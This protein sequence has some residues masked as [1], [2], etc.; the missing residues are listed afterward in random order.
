M[1]LTL[2]L[3]LLAQNVT[4]AATFQG[5]WDFLFELHERING[6]SHREFKFAAIPVV[7]ETDY[8]G[9]SW[10]L[11]FSDEVIA[12]SGGPDKPFETTVEI[13]GTIGTNE[14]LPLSFPDTRGTAVAGHGKIT[15]TGLTYSVTHRI[16]S[17]TQTRESN[18][19][20]ITDEHSIN[21]THALNVGSYPEDVELYLNNSSISIGLGRIDT[22]SGNYIELEM[23]PRHSCQCEVTLTEV[24]Q[25]DF[26]SSGE[27]GADDYTIW[28]DGTGLL[29]PLMTSY[30]SWKDNYGNAASD[31]SHAVIPEPTS[32][33]LATLGFAVVFC[34]R[35]HGQLSGW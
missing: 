18:S 23:Q 5:E 9:I 20:D 28:Q 3:L 8:S 10:Y 24:L 4:V 2:A 13:S 34:R 7:M 16:V 26:N 19:V 22:G 15:G 12:I 25:G 27:V 30:A 11:D 32:L 29:N 31:G 6:V 21:P 33:L 17:A 35:R 14:A 1:R